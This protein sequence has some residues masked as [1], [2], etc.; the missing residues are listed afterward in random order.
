VSNVNSGQRSRGKLIFKKEILKKKNLTY[1]R[2]VTRTL[3][4][5][6]SLEEEWKCEMEL[7]FGFVMVTESYMYIYG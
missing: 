1:N 7:G 4:Q 3:A 5:T 2:S 6:K